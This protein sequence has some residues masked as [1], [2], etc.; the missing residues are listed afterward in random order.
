MTI[1]NDVFIVVLTVLGL[2]RFTLLSIMAGY[3]IWLLTKV[4]SHRYCSS[5]DKSSNTSTYT[6]LDD[7]WVSRIHRTIVQRRVNLS[8]VAGLMILSS[9]GLGMSLLVLRQIIKIMMGESAWWFILY[10]QPDNIGELSY[11]VCSS[12]AALGAILIIRGLFKIVC[13]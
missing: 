7:T 4:G 13:P 3:S 2:V 12:L 10:R 1:F 5:I 9:S 11:G 6:S 8:T